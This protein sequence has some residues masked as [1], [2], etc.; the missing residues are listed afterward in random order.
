MKYRIIIFNLIYFLS[1]TTIYSQSVDSNNY[2][3]DSINKAQ[4]DLERQIRELEESKREIETQNIFKKYGVTST[5]GI[6][7]KLLD[8]GIM[9]TEPATSSPEFK[10]SIPQNEIVYAYK[11]FTEHRCWLINYNENWGFIDDYLIMAISEQHEINYE[12][13]WDTPPQIKTQIIPKYPKEAKKARIEGSVIVKIFIDKKGT[14][15]QTLILKGIPEL[16]SAAIETINKAKF[17][18]AKR[19]GKPVGVWTPI[20]INFKIK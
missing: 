6:K 10:F 3:L 11:Y 12:D 1:L 20:S 4:Q 13:Q 14:V 5:K 7:A 8:Y 16:N 19:N 15:T 18:P 17:T 9:R 2:N